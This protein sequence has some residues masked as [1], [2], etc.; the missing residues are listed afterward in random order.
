[1][2]PEPDKE[3]TELLVKTGFLKIAVRLKRILQKDV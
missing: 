3:A 1:M 2:R